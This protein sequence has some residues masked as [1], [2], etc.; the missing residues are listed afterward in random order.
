MTISFKIIL[1]FI[2]PGQGNSLWPLF[3]HEQNIWAFS[4]KWLNTIVKFLWRTGF[5]WTRKSKADLSATLPSY[6]NQFIVYF[7][8]F[9]QLLHALLLWR[10]NRRSYFL[11]LKHKINKYVS[12]WKAWMITRSSI[13][14]HTSLHIIKTWINRSKNPKYCDSGV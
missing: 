7:C 9:S 4:I 1:W 5:Y 2:Y 6:K 14:L 13:H 3:C 8:D 11:I 10:I 12:D